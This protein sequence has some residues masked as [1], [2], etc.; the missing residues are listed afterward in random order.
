MLGF[1]LGLCELW[2]W[3]IL[4]R[5][6]VFF[7]QAVSERNGRKR[8]EGTCTSARD[9]QSSSQA[10]A[11]VFFGAIVSIGAS[12]LGGNEGIENVCRP[13]SSGRVKERP[14][15]RVR[16]W[17]MM[18]AANI[19]R[20]PLGPLLREL[21]VSARV[22]ARQLRRYDFHCCLTLLSSQTHS[23]PQSSP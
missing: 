8:G 11:R 12:I 3:L 10:S 22:I 16:L 4:C 6:L 18:S 9:S 2:L 15:P 17:D 20:V 21:A 5:L 7:L 14:V 1:E 13:K 19:S 23:L